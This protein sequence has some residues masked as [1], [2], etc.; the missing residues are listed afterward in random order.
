MTWLAWLGWRFGKGRQMGRHIDQKDEANHNGSKASY[1]RLGE[2]LAMHRPEKKKRGG[3]GIVRV[4]AFI[5]CVVVFIGIKEWYAEGV[6]REIYLQRQ[7]A[8]GNPAPP[9]DVPGKGRYRDL[10]DRREQYAV[11][12]ADAKL[13]LC[14]MVGA[15][16]LYWLG[17]GFWKRHKNRMIG[18]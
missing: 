7:A 1:G 12:W 9:S 15:A 5:V 6:A 4:L 10:L 2:T 13:S 18:S 8:R 11:W 16:V 3:K 14:L 17:A